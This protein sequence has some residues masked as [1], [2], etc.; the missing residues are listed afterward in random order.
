[1]ITLGQVGTGCVTFPVPIGISEKHAA[2][3][4]F[5]EKTGDVLGTL[6]P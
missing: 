6:R 2:E 4:N 1:M 5:F 3:G